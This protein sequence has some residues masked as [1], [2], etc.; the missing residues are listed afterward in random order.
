MSLCDRLLKFLA[1][2]KLC[3]SLKANVML[4]YPIDEALELLG[5]N[6]KTAKKSLEQLEEELEFISDQC[7]TLEVGIL[8]SSFKGLH[9]TKKLF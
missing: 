4:E 6:L 1:F 8:C 9:Q 7:T 2:F 5:T 3:N